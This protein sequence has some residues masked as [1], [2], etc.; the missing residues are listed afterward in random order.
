MKSQ[1]MN[2]VNVVERLKIRK[3]YGL[4]NKS[5]FLIA[6]LLFFTLMYFILVI[7][8]VFS[9]IVVVFFF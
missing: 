1:V 5:D 6:E 9:V 2:R 3:R 7:S 4:K 8:F